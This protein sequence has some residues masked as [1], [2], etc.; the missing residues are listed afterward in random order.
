MQTVW[1]HTTIDT[2]FTQVTRM[3][4]VKLPKEDAPNNYRPLQLQCHILHR[5]HV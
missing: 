4:L 5:E 1:V 3:T 2:E